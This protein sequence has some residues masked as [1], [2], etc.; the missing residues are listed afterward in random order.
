MNTAEILVF[1]YYDQQSAEK[2]V[3]QN[4]HQKSL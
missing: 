4:I 1:Q 3:N 2:I